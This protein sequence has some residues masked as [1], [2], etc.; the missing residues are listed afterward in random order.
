M[1]F[2]FAAILAVA[3]CLGSTR[4]V[5]AQ[6]SLAEQA[7][8]SGNGEQSVLSSKD[9]VLYP[10][11]PGSSF[12]RFLPEGA[13]LPFDR[14]LELSAANGEK[15]VYRV[16]TGSSAALASGV[17]PVL[18]YVIDKRRPHSP[19]S[20]PGTGLYSAKLELALSAEEGDDIFWALVG[21]DGSMPSFSRYDAAS[22]PKLE[23]PSSGSVSYTL[24]AYAV[25]ASGMRSDPARFIYRLTEPGLTV[26]SPLA[27]TEILSPDPS[28]AAPK[29]ATGR[30]YTELSMTLPSGASLLL[31]FDQGAV[32]SSLEDFERIE[33]DESGL[34][35]FRINCPYAWS[36]DL[37][38]YYGILKG[39]SAS[40]SP[41]KL[42]VHLAYPT[43]EAFL[44]SVPPS[45]ILASDPAGRAAFIAFPAYDGDIYVSIGSA[46]SELYASPI[47]LPV[48]LTVA[49]VSWYGQDGSGRRSPTKSRSFELPVRIP[50]VELSGVEPF[51]S[52]GSDVLLKAVQDAGSS[53]SPKVQVRYEL[54]TDGSVPPEPGLSSPLLGDSLSISCP[55]GEER[56][57]VLRYR[58]FVGD[59][60]GE[61]RLLRFTLDKKPPEPPVLAETPSAYSDKSVSL[62]LLPG[63]GGKSVFASVST[64]GAAAPFTLVTGPIELTGSDSGPVD[65]TIRAYDVDAAG[66]KSQE[67]H[68]LSLVVDRASVYVAE[69]G[70][71]RGDGSPD[72][73]YKS[74]DAAFAAAS[75]GGKKSV[76]MRGT[77][78]MRN[79]ARF[80]SE[81]SLIGGFGPAW[82]KDPAARTVVRLLPHQGKASITQD[83][84]SL[85]IRRV[86]FEAEDTSN[87]LITL[88][89][90]SLFVSD[91]AIVAHSEGDLVIVSASRSKIGLS[92]SRIEGIAAMSLT[93]FSAEDSDIVVA[94]SS[95]SSRSGVRIFGAFDMNGG[96]LSLRESILE[97]ASDLGLNLLSLRSSS[98]SVDRSLIKVEGGSGFLRI[99]SFK[100]VSGE[101][102]NSKL[103]LSWN[104][105]GTL[106]EVQEGGP[107]LRHDTILADSKAALRF[108]DLSGRLPQLWNSIFDCSAPGSDFLRSDSVPAAG[109][110]VA[111]CVWGF[112]SYLS[113]ALESKDL[114]S[115][116]ALNALSAL[117][118][119]KPC[120]SESPDNSFSAP[121]KSQ[122]TLR[123]ESACVGAALPI[124]IGYSL[125]FSGHQRPAPG[126]TLPD[127]GADELGD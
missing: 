56:L 10:S 38:L 35:S 97:S 18:S 96:S 94:L 123:K 20:R 64:E 34:A 27:D 65:Y 95:I 66:N 112:D 93:A 6:G 49:T 3:A 100:A 127:I 45:P 44:P 86:E 21:P 76:N 58:C 88:S 30:G 125:D 15:R 67:M 25:G 72:R 63:S 75:R 68:S 12:F 119:S 89:A 40:Y 113:G 23:P 80:S 47:A 91:S 43:D 81:I 1:R 83:G 122:T 32:P 14:S 79:P 106:F 115:L 52:V 69:D 41:V 7:V 78:T 11:N 46:Q 19:Q 120:V 116:N 57:V 74:L 53:S 13:T 73:P 61:G 4:E 48:G 105:P 50:D 55:P 36:G 28:I 124:G 126:T 51:S 54:R 102:K 85:S 87:P 117:Y 16:Q 92:N 59:A 2:R 5:I 118:S 121:L 108:F 101:I 99:G 103:L 60:G 82:A 24:V 84:G 90:A 9:V 111:D 31:A 33:A 114:A 71:D 29:L 26:S 22:P 37:S 77:L 110:V 62:Q 17:A 42:S 8:A 70:S 109:I 98:L 104:G 39:N 107:A